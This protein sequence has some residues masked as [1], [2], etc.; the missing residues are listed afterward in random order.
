MSCLLPIAEAGSLHRR[1]TNFLRCILRIPMSAAVGENRRR[2]I[3]HA[4][5]QG[6]GR[7]SQ[8][9]PSARSPRQR[10]G[11]KPC[12]WRTPSLFLVEGS[13]G[14][15]RR[16]PTLQARDYPPLECG[17]RSAFL[18]IRSLRCA[19][20]HLFSYLPR[21]GGRA[22]SQLRKIAGSVS[23]ALLPAVLIIAILKEADGRAKVTELY[24]HHEISDATFYTWR[25]NYGGLRS[26]DA[27]A[28]TLE[29]E[30]R[31][32]KEM[33]RIRGSIHGRDGKKA[34]RPR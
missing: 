20:P 5:L 4:R 31:R 23:P 32:L 9:S 12:P 15:T 17:R 28:T 16:V 29:E 19:Y 13:D 24:R 33:G 2:L 27:Q 10:N 18:R 6:V 11:L 30:N 22:I 8:E 14:N 25:S 7:S 3:K 21:P 1:G 34:L 26:A